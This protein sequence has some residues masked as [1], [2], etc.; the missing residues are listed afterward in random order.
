MGYRPGRILFSK[1]CLSIQGIPELIDAASEY[2]ITPRIAEAE[3]FA[4]KY[5]LFLLRHQASDTNIDI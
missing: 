3:I 4:R 5:S 1:N 2:G